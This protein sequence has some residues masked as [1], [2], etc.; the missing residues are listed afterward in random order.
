MSAYFNKQT[1]N[2]PS[3]DISKMWSVFVLLK[4]YVLKNLVRISIKTEIVK[5]WTKRKKEV[6]IKEMRVMEYNKF[7]KITSKIVWQ[8]TFR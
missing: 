2:S 7:K 6:H 5:I 4:L 3:P 1:Q 8:I